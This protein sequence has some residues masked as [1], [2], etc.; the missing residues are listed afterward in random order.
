MQQCY[1]LDTPVGW[2]GC[3]GV[4]LARAGQVV[5]TG[6]PGVVGHQAGKGR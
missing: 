6:Q 3:V 2:C 1:S 4:H 5:V